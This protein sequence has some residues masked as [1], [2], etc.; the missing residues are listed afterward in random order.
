MYTRRRLKLGKQLSMIVDQNV[1]NFGFFKSKTALLQNS[2]TMAPL[3]KRTD[4]SVTVGKLIVS[5]AATWKG[6]PYSLIG[7]SSIKGKGGDC[8]GITFKIFRAA[9]CPYDYQQAASFPAYA[10]QSGL[11][12][13]LAPGEPKQEGDILCWP[14]HMAIYSSFASDLANARIQRQS[15]HG[16]GTWTQVSD[17]W[18]ASHPPRQ[19]GEIPPPYGPAEAKYWSPDKP[20]VFRYQK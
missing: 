8:S 10:L 12:R 18:T 15:R 4:V 9:N 13:Q 7:P 17:M 19:P 5:E 2:I 1:S 6:T 3:A 16:S 11:F 20:K 14:H